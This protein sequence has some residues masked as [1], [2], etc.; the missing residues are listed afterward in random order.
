MCGIYV[1]SNDTTCHGFPSS[2]GNATLID[3]QEAQS[4]AA[5]ASARHKHQTILAIVIILLLLLVGGAAG[6]AF[7]TLRKRR[8]ARREKIVATLP[9]QFPSTREELVMREAFSQDEP[10]PAPAQAPGR[11]RVGSD[12]KR[13]AATRDIEAPQY[14]EV[15]SAPLVSGSRRADA[16]LSPP[17]SARPQLPRIQTTATSLR[18]KKEPLPSRY[19]DSATVVPSSAESTALPSTAPGT[20]LISGATPGTVSRSRFA[21]FP[22]TSIRK[23]LTAGKPGAARSTSAQ[24]VSSTPA[25]AAAR[26]AR[27]ATVGTSTLGLP[28]LRDP[29][30][31]SGEEDQVIMGMDYQGAERR[32][33]PQ[34]LPPRY[35]SIKGRQPRQDG[36]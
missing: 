4:N 16:A 33:P 28:Q 7:W 25:R 29:L 15:V 31:V 11:W 18:E 9:T 36:D 26:V 13:S 3:Q 21:A 12:E 10:P 14:R 6:Y 20:A 24:A 1:G 30:F 34:G 2:S 32:R 19:L 5:A 27:N 23:S 17:S 8:Q 22:V 35:Q